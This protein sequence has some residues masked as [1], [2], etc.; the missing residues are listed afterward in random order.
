MIKYTTCQKEFSKAI[1]DAMKNDIII[2]DE[3]G[4]QGCGMSLAALNM[5]KHFEKI[6]KIQRRN[7]EN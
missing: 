2:L 4:I 3:R 7:N 5:A 1:K 6:K